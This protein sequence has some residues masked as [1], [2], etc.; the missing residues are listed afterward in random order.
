M[1]SNIFHASD[2]AIRPY[3]AKIEVW[4]ILQYVYIFI[5]KLPINHTVACMLEM[6]DA[7]YFIVQE[8]NQAVLAKGAPYARQSCKYNWKRNARLDYCD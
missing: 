7:I 5:Y 3:M 1:H 6:P 4:G 8:L 2:L